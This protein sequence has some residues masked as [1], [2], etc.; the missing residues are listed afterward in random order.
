MCMVARRRGAGR[1]AATPAHARGGARV[2]QGVA[3]GVRIWLH[4]ALPAPGPVELWCSCPLC[5]AWRQ[6]RGWSR[7]HGLRRGVRRLAKLCST[8]SAG[9]DAGVLRV[10]AI[11]SLGVLAH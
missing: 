7:Q 1:R 5:W 11:V 3:G 2:T 6:A 10:V 9:D 4:L 8:A